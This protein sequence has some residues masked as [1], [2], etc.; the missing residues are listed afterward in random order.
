MPLT[1]SGSTKEAIA[2]QRDAINDSC[3]HGILKLLFRERFHS[4][5]SSS[6]DESFDTIDGIK[7]FGCE[8]GNSIVFFWTVTSAGLRAGLGAD[9]ETKRRPNDRGVA[10]ELTPEQHSKSHS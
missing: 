4:R 5:S 1:Q 9:S 10:I 8:S 2:K 6:T 7:C 3:R